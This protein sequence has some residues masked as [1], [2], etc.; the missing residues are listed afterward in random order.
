MEK[1]TK[2]INYYRDRIDAI[3]NDICQLSNAIHM[4]NT[5]YINKK[6]LYNEIEK[7]SQYKKEII[8][9]YICNN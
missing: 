3:D 8:E 5:K 7:L 2:D 4:M 9:K 1:E 6:A